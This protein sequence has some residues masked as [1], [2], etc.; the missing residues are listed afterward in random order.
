M[1]IIM[2][3]FSQLFFED[4][5]CRLGKSGNKLSYTRCGEL[6][7]YKLTE[8]GVNRKDFGLHNLR[9]QVL[10]QSLKKYGRWKSDFT[11]DG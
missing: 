7:F 10:Q 2:Y 3:I 9:Y 1:Y 8:L 5:C 6:I 11:K 4:N